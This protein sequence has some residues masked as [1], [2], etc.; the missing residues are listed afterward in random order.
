MAFNL[1]G[2]DQGLFFIGNTIAN[3]GL[4][5]ISALPMIILCGVCVAALFFAKD[6][7][8]PIRVLIINI[9]F[10]EAC[11][12]LGLT[13]RFLAYAPR[14]KL[15]GALVICKVVLNFTITGATQKFFATALYA[16]MVYIFV[17][18]GIKKLKWKIIIPCIALSWLYC[19]LFGMIVYF[20]AF[21]LFES[22]GFCDTNP[23]LPLFRV[24]LVISIVT[25][26]GLLSTTIV[27]SIMTYVYIK[28]NTLESNVEVKKAVMKNLI[29]LTF[30]VI[31]SFIFNMV[32]ATF[33]FIRA[34]FE[35]K[36][37]LSLIVINYVLRVFLNVPSALT[38]IAAMITLKPIRLAMRQGIERCCGCC[39]QNN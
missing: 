33:P 11:S 18:F 38:P 26:I 36:G 7:N 9:F 4:F 15:R 17:R 19:I 29:Y 31:F 27:F 6:I 32:P 8:W 37:L 16:I 39:R 35:D 3:I 30:S 1:T 23:G 28:K 21:G 5:V 14:A 24:S 34:A 22:S 12:W 13:L 20:N 25:S 2:I 10:A